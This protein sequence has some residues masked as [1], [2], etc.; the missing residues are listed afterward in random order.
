MQ[1]RIKQWLAVLMLFSITGGGLAVCQ[2]AG[3]PTSAPEPTASPATAP[4]SGAVV[5]L[6]E[7][8]LPGPF[9]LDDY[10]AATPES[11]P[12]ATAAP[13]EPTPAAPAVEPTSA[14]SVE[15]TPAPASEQ[16]ATL[17]SLRHSIN[18]LATY[19]TDM[20]PCARYAADLGAQSVVLTVLIFQ[21][22]R[23]DY[24]IE[25]DETLT[26]S[27]EHTR[28]FI[29]V[30]HA[31]KLRVIYKPILNLRDESHGAWRGSI[32]A[33]EKAP[34]LWF[35]NYKRTLSVLLASASA[36]DGVVVGNEFNSLEVFDVQ[37]RGVVQLARSRMPD[38][39][40]IYEANWDSLLKGQVGWWDAVDVM[41]VSAYFPL[42]TKEPD[43]RTAR[44]VQCWQTWQDKLVDFA[45]AHEKPLWFAEFGVAARTAR[46]I[47]PW[48]GTT[49]TACDE[50]QERWYAAGIVAWDGTEDFLGLTFWS[51]LP[52][53]DAQGFSFVGK[54]AEK[55]LRRFFQP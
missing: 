49:G 46:N 42:C 39:V 17:T 41:A 53:E 52:G 19:D 32:V 1:K 6:R 28:Q 45:K 34:S 9:L 3:S 54:P 11:T 43:P 14:L 36:A 35:E 16:Q 22:S 25:T 4:A 29:E 18:C 2:T 47:K 15:P 5:S 20:T 51:W 7:T 13:P 24:H 21:N 8:A 30:A 33:G 48:D 44:L 38:G 40:V 31:L 55:T 12:A 37:W 50:C 23:S 26:L 10:M 27:G